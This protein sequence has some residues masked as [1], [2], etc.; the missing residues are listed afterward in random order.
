MRTYRR[1]RRRS[2]GGRR[3][4]RKNKGG[5]TKQLV[6]GRYSGF[7]QAGVRAM[8]YVLNSIK[9]LKQLVNSEEHYRDVQFNNTFTTAGDI[10]LLS[11]IAQGDTDI[12]RSGNKVLFKD[13]IFRANVNA[14]SVP[15]ATTARIIMFVDKECD[16]SNPTV[17]QVLQQAS[18]HSP[19]NMDFSKRFVVLKDWLFGYSNV[20]ILERVVKTYKTLNFHGFYDGTTVTVTDCKEN[21]IFILFISDAATNAP[22]YSFWSRIKFYDN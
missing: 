12:T 1:F 14:S 6:D 9:M 7:I 19:L 17:A 15:S 2:R 8:P 11:G 5:R 4:I 20:G 18:V 13:I 10:Q 22:G 21:Q 3:Y 16:G